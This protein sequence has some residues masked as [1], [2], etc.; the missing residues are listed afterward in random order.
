MYYVIS[1][2]QQVKLHRLKI[3]WSAVMCAGWAIKD[4]YLYTCT[5][6]RGWHSAINTFP[7]VDL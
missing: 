6:V 2:M 4:C 3:D 5:D 1:E 7:E